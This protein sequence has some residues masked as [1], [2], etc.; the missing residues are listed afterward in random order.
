[1]VTSSRKLNSIYEI[2]TAVYLDRL[3]RTL[4]RPVT[5]A[6]IPNEEMSRIASYGC[7]AVWLMGIWKR[8]QDAIDS[9]RHDKPLLDEIRAVLPDFRPD[10]I[11]GS[12]YA[13][14]AYEVSDAF[15]GEIGL[16]Q[17][18]KRLAEYGLKLILDF[19]PNHTAFDHAWTIPHSEYYVLG[20]P[21]D[22]AE[23]PSWYRQAGDAVVAHGR[24]PH[25]EPWPDV[26]QL[27]AFAPGYRQASIDTLAHIA[28]LCDG[29]RCDM[30]MLMTNDIFSHTWGMR[31]DTAPLTEYWQEVITKVRE[32]KEDFIFIAE[33]Y[34]DMQ[35]ALINQGFDYCYDKDL[36]DHL[37]ENDMEAAQARV[38]KLSSIGDHMLHFLENHDEPRAARMFNLDAHRTALN[39]ISALPGPRLW[40]DGQ[41]EGYQAKLPVHIGRGPSEPIDDAIAE[42]YRDLLQNK[43]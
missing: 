27:N 9:A 26:A 4:N 37:I 30:A 8:S 25:F 6:T 33:C 10:D 43:S 20:T 24:D 12:A 31:V 14:G 5:L 42:I 38:D 16:I 17:L 35:A 2:N 28:T 36:Y 34:W 41:F 23:H 22:I 15:G 18:R 39:F 19:V 21:S 13:I 3:S 11:I 32:E 1:M 40:H 7:D 29:V